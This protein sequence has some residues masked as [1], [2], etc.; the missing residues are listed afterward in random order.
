MRINV[1]LIC[2]KGRLHENTTEE[3]VSVHS[4]KFKAVG[5][6][7]DFSSLRAITTKRLTGNEPKS[8]RGIR[9]QCCQNVR[10]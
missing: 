3:V 8:L 7:A 9:T 6:T 1:Y 2:K 10:T 5:L 4:I